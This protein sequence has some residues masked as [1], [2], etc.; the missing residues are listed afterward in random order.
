[1][2]CYWVSLLVETKLGF[3]NLPPPQKKKEEEEEKKVK[4]TF[5]RGGR[6]SNQEVREH[7]LNCV[8]VAHFLRSGSD[9]LRSGFP[10]FPSFE[11]G[12][13]PFFF[14]GGAPIS[15]DCS[16]GGGELPWT[17]DNFL[18]Q[19]VLVVNQQVCFLFLPLL[20]GRR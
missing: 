9:W 16:F 5:C 7:S 1:M 20:S 15:S 8:S 4:L 11:P 2:T 6:Y 17:L 12:L 10:L 13:A 18:A 3:P 14:G 19:T